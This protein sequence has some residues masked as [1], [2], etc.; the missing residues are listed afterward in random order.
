MR[1]QK[2]SP[3]LNSL[4]VVLAAMALWGT[5]AQADVSSDKPGSVVIWPKVIADGT[6]DT[7]ISLTNTRNEQAYAHCEYVQA[8]GICSVTGSFCSVPNAAP[9]SPGACEPLAGNVCTQRWQTA[10]FDVAL[11]RQQPTIWRVST[12]RID[13]PFLPPDG[14]C[15]E[16]LPQ[17]PTDAVT[18]SCPGIFLIG[19]VPPVVQPFRGQLTCI[20]VNV[21]GSA[22]G[23][24]G[25]KGEAT[26]ETVGS[27]QISTYNSINVQAIEA[28]G[29]DGLVRLNGIEY[30]A[31]P[32]AVEVSHY[33][34]GAEDLVAAAIDPA[35]CDPTAGCPVETEITLSPCRADYNG[36]NPAR[37]ATDIQ[38]TN[39]FEQT[40]SIETT[41]ECWAN[42]DLRDLG[43][44]PAA[45]TGSQFQ[46]TRLTP[47]GSGRCVL[48]DINAACDEDSDC[49]TGGVCGPVTGILA[50]VEEF[51]NTAASLA[52]PP[53]LPPGTAAANGYSV[54]FNGSLERVGHC[55]NDLTTTCRSNT[56]CPSGLC[57]LS[58]ASCP[59]DL[60]CTGTGDFCDRCMND[61][62][63]FTAD[64]I[65]IPTPGQ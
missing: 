12:G 19:R 23:S 41:F 63:T 57:R 39:E 56:E 3:W 8:L 20:Q 42:F 17:N 10:D 30:S 15:V 33:S 38:Y 9:G 5:Q 36:E 55:R 6:R 29:V 1:V 21:D 16:N 18:Q 28:G 27:Q 65:A 40:L 2:R 4:G 43:F 60:Q 14:A 45:S 22:N 62:I 11:T 52:E 54:A 58:G 34:Q 7:L 35:V 25:L 47:T 32:P 48:G 26:I 49:G 31:C 59:T 53:T 44:A 51:H 61:E 24:N 64:P 13:N 50:I 37:W 46:R